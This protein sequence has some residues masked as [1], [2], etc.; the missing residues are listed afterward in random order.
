[1]GGY[2]QMRTPLA[3]EIFAMANIHA[4]YSIAAPGEV[5]FIFGTTAEHKGNEGCGLMN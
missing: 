1:M 4:R 3:R 2:S 5:D